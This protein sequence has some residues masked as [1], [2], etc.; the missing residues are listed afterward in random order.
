[1]L[2]VAEVIMA[3]TAASATVVTSSLSAGIWARIHMAATRTSR[4]AA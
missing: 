3:K 1:M 4:D 2:F